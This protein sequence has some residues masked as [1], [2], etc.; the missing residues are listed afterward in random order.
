MAYHLGWDG[1][2]SLLKVSLDYTPATKD[3]TVFI[4]GDP[5]FGG[6]KEIFKVLQ[7]IESK[8][9]IKLT[10]G[11]RKITV[12]HT[13]NELKHISYTINGHLVGNPKRSTVDELFR[14][15]IM[16]DLLYL[17]PKFFVINAVGNSA[18]TA[19]IQWDLY[20]AGLPYFFSSSAGTGPA[21]KQTISLTNENDA[22]IL[23]GSSLLINSYEVHGI[24]Y[25]SIT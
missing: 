3:S 9:K 7:N 6:Q 15:L 13:D 21:Q 23:M 16:P 14:L 22:L 10:P 8:D 25:Y 18:T 20:P 24:P 4:Y 2:S 1:K 11:E 5:S 17:V 19:S 12:Y